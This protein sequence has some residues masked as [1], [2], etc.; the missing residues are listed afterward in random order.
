MAQVRRTGGAFALAEVDG[1]P[2]TA[3]ALVF[4]GVDFP[5]AHGQA[6]SL[7]H[8]GVGFALRCALALGLVQ[9]KTDDLLEFENSLQL[10]LS[11]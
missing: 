5:Q 9:H 3:I 1:E 2:K 4:D 11:H 7:A 6:E 8:A 10:S